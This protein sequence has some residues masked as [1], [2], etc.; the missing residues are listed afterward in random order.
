[1]KLLSQFGL[2]S[3]LV[4]LTILVPANAFAA[5][6]S[7]TQHSHTQTVHDRTPTVHTHSAHSHHHG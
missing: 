2:A 5:R 6:N 1:M 3:V 7:G 4:V